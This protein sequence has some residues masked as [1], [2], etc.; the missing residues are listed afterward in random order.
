MKYYINEINPTGTIAVDDTLLVKDTLATAGSHILDGFKPLFSAEAV[1]RLEKAGYDIAGK[2]NVGE[3]GLD[4]LGE[5]SYFADGADTVLKGAAAE[6]VK[7]GVTGTLVNEI[8]PEG[9][10]LKIK[11][12]TDNED[13]Y[14]S[15]RENCKNERKEAVVCPIRKKNFS[16]R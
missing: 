10:A 11:E 1:E 6:L 16:A 9:I 12:I 2:T 13:Y 3:F 4:L 7:D 8:T 14:N 15:L 5:T